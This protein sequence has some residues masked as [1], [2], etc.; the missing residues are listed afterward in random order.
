[1][2]TVAA[3][4]K[5]L[6][7]LFPDGGQRFLQDGGLGASW[8]EALAGVPPQLLK[9]PPQAAGLRQLSRLRDF[10]TQQNDLRPALAASRALLDIR[11][12]VV[13][14]DHPDTYMELGALGALGL[15]GRLTG[16]AVGDELV[17]VVPGSVEGLPNPSDAPL[18]AVLWILG[19]GNKER[20][21]PVIDAARDA[22]A[23]YLRLCPHPM[24]TDTA[25][26]LG[27][28]GGALNPRAVQGVM[29]RA[30]AQLGLP[31]TATPHAMRHSFATHLL[32]AGGD[33]RAIQ[34]LLGHASLSTT[35]A[36]TAVDTAQ[37]MEVY[38]R[39]HP[40]A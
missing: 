40:H 16:D 28:R 2:D 39:A 38:D 29:A 35:Q 33:L 11:A 19:K 25:L 20:V 4:P 31:A 8:G 34:D 26:F 27:V 17:H 1:M 32:A 37:L 36:Y 6:A 10:W 24:Q 21:V 23:V 3:A 9:V 18:P 13:G 15:A 7:R 14:Q 5:L 12:R 30:R 22:V